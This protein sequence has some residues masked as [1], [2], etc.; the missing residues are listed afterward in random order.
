[1]QNS[2]SSDI[3]SSKPASHLQGDE[4]ARSQVKMIGQFEEALANLKMQSLFKEMKHSRSKGGEM[5]Y[6]YVQCTQVY[7]Y[8]G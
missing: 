4:K 2:L 3:R 1:M 8:H 5:F 6:F 7:V